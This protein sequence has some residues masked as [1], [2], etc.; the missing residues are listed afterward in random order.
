GG[1]GF[2][3]ER[4][5]RAAVASP[6]ARTRLTRTRGI[7][8]D[9]F[10]FLAAAVKAGAPKVTIPAPD[11]MHFFLGPR[12]VD[13]GVYPDIEEY[14]ADLVAIYQAEIADLAALGCRYLQ[15]DDTA[16]PCNC[17]DRMRAEVR[18]RGEDPD[19]LTRRYVALV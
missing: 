7:A 16:L 11:V 12:S 8:T 14:Y 13:T 5:Q 4:G 18:A 3:D 1:L 9:E 2:R 15:L 10:R 17:D 19:A 6:Y